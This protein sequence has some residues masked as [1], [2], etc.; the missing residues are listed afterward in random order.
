MG[1][2][3]LVFGAFL[4]VI[5]MLAAVAFT[6]VDLVI[7]KIPS[8]EKGV[9]LGLDLSGGSI[10]IFEPDEA[11][12]SS[13]DMNRAVALLRQRLDALGLTEANIYQGGNN[14][15]RVE[16]PGLTD[17]EE[18]VETIGSTAQLEFRDSDDN[19]IMSGDAIVE[20]KSKFG[21]IDNT[22]VSVH[23]VEMK[24]REDSVALWTEAT[25]TAA[26]KADGENYIAIVLDGETVFS[27]SVDS[28]YASTGIE[29]DT[30][31]VSFGSSNDPASEAKRFAALVQ[32]G[33]LPFSLKEAGTS[34][35]GPTLGENSLQSSL[36]AG[37]IG[38]GLVIL[39]MI[40]VYRL[41]G[42][43]AG[44]SLCLYTALMAIILSIASVNLTLPGIAGIIL[45]I[46]MAVDANVIIFERI[47]EE[48]RSGKT[49]ASSVSAGYKRALTAIIDSNITTIIAAVVLL[50]FGSGPIQGFA[51]TLLIGVLLSMFTVL[52]VSRLLLNQMVKLGITNT[53][54]YGV[55]KGSTESRF[56]RSSFS[57]VK[58][59]K[60]FGIV[61]LLLA[62]VAA[63]A[64]VL[65]PFGVTLFNLDIDF[66]GGTAFHY[67][68]GVYMDNDQLNTVTD[69][70][71]EVT[72]VAP[73]AP[74]RAGDDGKEVMIKTKAEVSSDKRAEIL[75][76][77]KETFPDIA[78]LSEDYVGGSV[79]EDIRNRAL[80]SAL[81]ASALIL[82]YI[83]IRFQF[84]SG[85]A[86]V[87]ALIHDLLIMIVGYLVLQIPLNMNL[88]AAMLT[89][90]GYSINSTIIVFDR[91]RENRRVMQKMPFEDIVD[92]S[93][94]QTITRNI[95][96]TLT[97]L[98]PVIMIIIL[99]VPSVREFAIP[100]VIGMVAGAYSSICL[101]G[102][103]W[104]KIR[105]ADKNAT[106][107]TAN[108]QKAKA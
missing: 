63:V 34:T 83:T 74:Q 79:S 48:L 32:V 44:I 101:S 70:I 27:P 12:P 21:P 54:L 59:F 19:L 40:F 14:Q 105:T 47:K 31:V 94:K 53:F 95:N 20:A 45:T 103:L 9:T 36:L 22:N 90:L 107:N 49:V 65:L 100:L 67:N 46:G 28:K 35:V 61:S 56:I 33:A 15:I 29:G 98:L 96:T 50:A 58:N 10:I 7:F 87:L 55:S 51:I 16:I 5:V 11:N 6:G 4:L 3:I 1:K 37:A 84:S 82:I 75:E 102:S 24:F 88:I 43:M 30:C 72:G 2:N 89:I 41:P 81:L 80:V 8:V 57:F 71:N 104:T 69:T 25:K 68:T 108:K 66:V 91:I 106:K 92:R 52:V 18:A 64:L 60:K 76:K 93:I 77:L 73:G 17:T 86:A 38:L 42:L 99:G 85:L 23:H 62:I 97:T 78:V 39:F 13:E 26:G